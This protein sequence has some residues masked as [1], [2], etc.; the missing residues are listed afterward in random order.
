MNIKDVAKMAGVSISTVSRVINNTAKVNED[1]RARVE[2]VLKETNYRPNVL[3]RELQQRKTNT[4]GV[5][6]AAGDLNLISISETL[7]TIT[8]IL[9]DNGYNMMLANS[10]F[11]L[12]EEIDIFRTFQEKRV[13]GVLFM[14]HVFHEEHYEILSNYPAPVVLIGQEYKRLGIAASIHDDFHA[15]RDATLYLL[16]KGH[17][18]IGFIGCPIHDEATGIK[19]RRGFEFA[20]ESFNLKPDESI[21]T[22]GD[23]SIRSGYRAIEDMMRS[24]AGM[25]SAVFATTD[26]MAIGAIKAL[27]DNGFRVP[28][29]V[30]VMGF[31]DVNVAAFCDP[32]LTTIHTDKVQVGRAAATHLLD[33][34]SSGKVEKTLYT[35][36]YTL[37][38][39]ESVLDKNVEANDNI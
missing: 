25:P 16:E 6:M 13:D 33:S 38:E 12:Q 14:A 1:T 8:D 26:Y 18:R 31:D 37:K 24:Q 22:V 23:F 3:A 35:S 2:K 20:L 17:D 32:P 19:R 11:N 30:S 28:E 39:R 9:R 29:D 27:K 36:T 7:N 15:A 21:M 5:L 4:I 34:I 10:R